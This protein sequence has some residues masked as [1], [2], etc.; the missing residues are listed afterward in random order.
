MIETDRIGVQVVFTNKAGLV[1]MGLHILGQRRLTLIKAGKFVDSVTMRVFAGHNH[2]PTRRANRVGHKR[3]G[4]THAFV[5]E[6]IKIGRWS[7]R[8]QPSPI[9]TDCMRRMIVRHD[10]EDIQRPSGAE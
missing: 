1:I 7:H 4:E 3:I 5:S 9:R 2:R 8:S 10:I 6:S